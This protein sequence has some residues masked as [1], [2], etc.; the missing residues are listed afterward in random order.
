MQLADGDNMNWTFGQDF[1]NSFFTA[2]KEA[3]EQ[4]QFQQKL[5]FEWRQFELT[6]MFREKQLESQSEIKLLTQQN[7]MDR[8]ETSQ[9][10]K[11]QQG[12]FS[13]QL[14]ASEYERRKEADINRNTIAEQGLEIKR[15]QVETAR[16]KLEAARNGQEDKLMA[17]IATDVGSM[18]KMLSIYD[19]YKTE[20]DKIKYVN[21]TGLIVEEA[22]PQWRASYKKLATQALLK[23]GI[24][25]NSGVGDLNEIWRE[26]K[27]RAT[28]IGKDFDSLTPEDKQ[29]I[30]NDALNL[31]DNA[32]EKPFN[33][34]QRLA[35]EKYLMGK[36]R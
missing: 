25:P 3:Q 12:E 31:V 35:L 27:K 22:K 21:P 2:K 19:Q 28:S 11:E 13:N 10:F 17:K 16:A 30:L 33:S 18:D 36:I 6:N 24:N 1:L 14:K 26:A 20:N 9:K 8:Y 4:E 32:R 23:S 7:L 15:Q 34:A 29:T 5:G